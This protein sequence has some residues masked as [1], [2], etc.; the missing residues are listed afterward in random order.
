MAYTNGKYCEDFIHH[1]SF[2]AGTVSNGLSAFSKK[3][4]ASSVL[5]KGRLNCFKDFGQVKKRLDRS[6]WI[7]N[8]GENKGG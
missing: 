4:K 3:M 1:L 6:A 8:T 2:I 7:R 5:E